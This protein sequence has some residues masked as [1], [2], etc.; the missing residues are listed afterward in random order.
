MLSVC[1]CLCVYVCMCVGVYVGGMCMW[2]GEW[3]RAWLCAHMDKYEY[4]FFLLRLP[5]CNVVMLQSQYIII[6]S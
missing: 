5:L 3:A 4:S 6:Y 1:A 2:V